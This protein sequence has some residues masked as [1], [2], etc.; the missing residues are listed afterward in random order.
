MD[1]RDRK[2][3]QGGRRDESEGDHGDM[4]PDPRRTRE[5]Q[6]DDRETQPPMREDIRQDDTPKAG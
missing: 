2:Q 4:K 5:P 1:E 3:D 6:D